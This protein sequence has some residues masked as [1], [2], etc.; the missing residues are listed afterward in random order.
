LTLSSSLC[1]L[2]IHATIFEGMA[3]HI[4][5]HYAPDMRVFPCQAK[6]I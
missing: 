6:Y 2:F 5:K 4:N 1:D 3:S